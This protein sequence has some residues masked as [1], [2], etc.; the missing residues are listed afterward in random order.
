[1][2]DS[3]SGR[4]CGSFHSA[5]GANRDVDHRAHLDGYSVR[6]PRRLK[7]R[8]LFG[9]LCAVL[10]IIRDL[11]HHLLGYFVLH[12]I[13]K[14]ARFV[15]AFAPVLSVVNKGGRHK[16]PLTRPPQVARTSPPRFH[17]F[18]TIKLTTT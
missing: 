17:P 9:T 15:G 12:I 10:V 2:V 7:L 4:R 8:P 14:T 6:S 5:R 18:P 16:V 1:M 3:E 13:G 11:K